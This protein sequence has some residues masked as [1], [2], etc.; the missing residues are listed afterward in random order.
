[1]RVRTRAGRVTTRLEQVGVAKGLVRGSFIVALSHY[2][3]FPGKSQTLFLAPSKYYFRVLAWDTTLH[4]LPFRGS[5][6]DADVRLALPELLS[7]DPRPG[8]P[9]PDD[10]DD[11]DE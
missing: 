9:A 8:I 2:F 4:L 10:A 5:P 11:A 7:A 1:M 3:H 6:F